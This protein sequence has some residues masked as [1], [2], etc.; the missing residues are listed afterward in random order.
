MNNIC[1]L[2]HE[3]KELKESH[4]I[5]KFVG[6]WLK[7]TSATGYLRNID[8]I[9]KRQQ[10]IIKDYLLCNDCELIFSSWEK[11]FSEKIFIPFLDQKI[12]IAEYKDWLAK[13]CASLSWRT[14]IYIKNKN[15]NFENESEYFIGQINLAELNLRNFLL[16][17]QD[18]LYQYEQHIFPLSEIDTPSKSLNLPSNINRYFLRSIGIDVLQGDNHIYIFTKL[19]TF[20]ILGIVSSNFS[21]KMRAGRVSLKQGIFRPSTLVMPEYLLGYMRNKALEIQEKRESMSDEQQNKIDKTALEN[22]DKTAD[23]KSF[24]AIM[25]D[26]NIFGNTIFK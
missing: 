7:K 16:G 13:F 5:P 3:S 10:D 22:L 9:N 19:P 6:K 11:Q 1:A 2:C 12:Y 25:H 15:S 14:L 8:N 20:L 4:F 17:K 24:E 26:Y 18:N 23:S 21:S